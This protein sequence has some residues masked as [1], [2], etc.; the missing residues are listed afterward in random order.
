MPGAAG[1]TRVMDALQSLALVAGM[2]M[3]LLM[4]TVFFTARYDR[5]H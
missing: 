5:R 3:A 1:K 2:M 4:L